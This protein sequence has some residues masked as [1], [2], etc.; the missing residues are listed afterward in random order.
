M[1]QNNPNFEHFVKWHETR[2][3]VVEIKGGEVRLFRYHAHWSLPVAARYG[4]CYLSVAGPSGCM[5]GTASRLRQ[6]R[7][8]MKDPWAVSRHG[9]NLPSSP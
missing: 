2:G 1:E 6:I 4:D 3:R 9:L 7:G 5:K 8:R